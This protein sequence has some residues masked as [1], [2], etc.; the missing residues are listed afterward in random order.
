MT[1]IVRFENDELV[2]LDDECKLAQAIVHGPELVVLD[3]LLY[4]SVNVFE[5]ALRLVI[6]EVVLA[7]TAPVSVLVPCSRITA[8]SSVAA[9]VE[10]PETE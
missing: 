5:P 10:A 1:V 8:R 4:W 9:C 3:E 2:V 6:T 7:W